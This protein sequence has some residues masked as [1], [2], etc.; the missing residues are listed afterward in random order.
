MRYGSSFYFSDRM[1]T[2]TYA[3]VVAKCESLYFEGSPTEE[4]FQV[5]A[6]GDARCV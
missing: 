3:D 1:Y 2:G 5:G 4:E 6:V